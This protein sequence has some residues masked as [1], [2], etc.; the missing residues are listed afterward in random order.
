M[1]TDRNSKPAIIAAGHI[2]LDITPLFPANLQGTRPGD[3]LVPG[4]LL[5]TEGVNVSTGGSVA[6]T[7]LALK[8]LGN[9][10]TLM[11]KVGKDALGAL[12]QQIAASYGADGL[13]VD[14]DSSTSYSVVLAVPGSDRIFLHSPGA[15]DT[16]CS[17]DIPEDALEDATL[18]HFGYPPLMTRMYE[19]GGRELQTIFSRMK[20]HSIATSLD[21]AAVDPTSPAGRVNWETILTNTLPFVDFFV[22]SFEE[23][24][25]MLD[26][27]KYDA[28]CALGGDM[29][30]HLDME[31]D[32]KP[33]ADKCL[34]LGC[35]AVLIKC[36]TA[37]MYWKTGTM[38]LIGSRLSLDRKVWE[39]KEGHQR[40]FR[41]TT[42][43]SATGAGDVSIAAY[44]TGIL[45]GKAPEVCAALAAAEGACAVTS[46]D[47]LGGL[48][49]LEALEA[50]I[51]AG[52]KM[53]P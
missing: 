25:F 3:L 18:F 45:R 49:P 39:N 2:C 33:L 11:G 40:C 26:R 6:N 7:G 37:G 48:Q 15:N 53:Y 50:R 36:G 38:E 42:V 29:T 10:V 43:R 31:R 12:V 35:G 14:E 46:Y 27:P 20:A 8:L 23:L 5:H 52:W 41:A 30:E 28:L 9:K 34:S 4:K 17:E 32:V 22:P 24:C 13:L 51:E 21:L 1:I 19:N 47:A 16:F 44:L